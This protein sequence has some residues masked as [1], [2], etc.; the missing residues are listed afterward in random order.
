MQQKIIGFHQDE[1]QHW[2]A[3]LCCGHCQHVRHD[4]PWQNR[5]WVTTVEGRSE[6]LATS[7]ECK[8]CDMPK[9][10]PKEQLKPLNTSVKITQNSLPEELLTKDA[11]P[12]NIWSEISIISGQIQLLCSS[13][14]DSSQTLGFLLN[15]EFSG[16]VAPKRAFCLKPCGPVEFRI[17]LYEAISE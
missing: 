4:P 5:P 17:T 14:S 6:K 1:E 9:L 16:I 8:M 2:V 12:D 3:E 13:Q 15:N 7:L 11:L 10:P